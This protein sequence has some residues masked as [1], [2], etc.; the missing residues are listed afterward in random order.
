MVGVF[1]LETLLKVGMNQLIKVMWL[2]GL[3]GIKREQPQA[4]FVLKR[5]L[6][7][8]RGMSGKAVG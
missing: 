1:Y 7:Q 4:S 8:P 3:I 2:T 6:L 5:E